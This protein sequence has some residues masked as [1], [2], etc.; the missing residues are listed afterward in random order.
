MELEKRLET[1]KAKILT[2][3]EEAAKKGDTEEIISNSRIV[4]EVERLIKRW[5]EIIS[6]V[7]VLEKRA[8]SATN[9]SI[10]PEKVIVSKIFDKV[11]PKK[12]GKVNRN[13]LISKLKTMGISLSHFEGTT[14]KTQNEKLVGIAYASERLLNRWFLGLPSKDYNSVIL[15]CENK[16]G[17]F[18]N[19]VL[20]EDFLRRYLNKLSHDDYGQVKFNIFLK[21]GHYQLRIPGEGYN[22]IDNF[23]NNYYSLRI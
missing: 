20:P 14:Y 9:I 15:I 21:G 18:L 5:E 1:L 17:D 7:D 16:N 13:E 10:Q 12:K 8:D 6:V 23:Q 3:I 19:F 11:S 22:N 4:E 2:K